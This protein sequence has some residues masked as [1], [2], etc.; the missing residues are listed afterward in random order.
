MIRIYPVRKTLYPRHVFRIA[1]AAR[2]QVDN[3]FLVLEQDGETGYGEASPNAYFR[4]D[5][6]DVWLSLAALADYFRRQTLRS[7]GDIARIW[8]EVRE[9]V[10]PSR[11]CLCAVDL[12]LWDLLGKLTRRGVADL[13][14]GTAPRD[15]PTSATIGICP[16]GEWAGRVAEAAGFP[17][18]KLK[19]G[20][21]LDLSLLDA[22]RAGSRAA[23]R[24]DANCAWSAMDEKTLARV[25]AEL[26]DRGVEF[27]E[28]PFPREDDARMPRALKDSRLPILADESCATPEEVEALAGRFSGFNIKLVKCGGIT[29]ALAML[30]SGRRLGLKVM[31]GCMLESS[32]LIA[33]GAVVAQGADYADL[34]GAW[35]LRHDPFE[36]LSLVDGKLRLSAAPGL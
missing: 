16:P 26:A 18:I 1:R 23:I 34:D 21:D 25:S 14:H 36:G 6:F 12:A 11:A 10:A 24:V 4:E 8:G 20:A 5:P 7:T 13:V 31:V 33:A 27:L 2:P 9:K 29:P 22:V 28:Q 15:I 30:E 32:L 17:A 19:V 35:L 3:I